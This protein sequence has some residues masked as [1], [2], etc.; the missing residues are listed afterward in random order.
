MAFAAFRLSTVNTVYDTLFT[1]GSVHWPL[2]TFAVCIPAVRAG[3]WVRVD[4]WTDA[5]SGGSF[6]AVAPVVSGIVL[7]LWGGRVGCKNFPR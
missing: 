1:F 2:F 4:A 5:A 7:L 3:G 6:R